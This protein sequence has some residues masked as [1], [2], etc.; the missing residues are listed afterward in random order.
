VLRQSE[1]ATLITIRGFRDVDYVNELAA[2]GATAGQVPTL[3]RLV[4][5]GPST[6]A[7]FTPYEDVRAAAARISDA[8]LD[9]RSAGIGPDD[10]INM[11]YTS[12]TTGFPK[13]V[14]LSSRNIVN[15]GEALGRVLGYTPADRLCLC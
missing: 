14:M 5:V 13:G 12:G 3:R 10:V 15:N 8:E 7:G 2:I 4:F 6:P 11:Q 9:S 1:A